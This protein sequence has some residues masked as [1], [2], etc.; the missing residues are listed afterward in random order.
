MRRCILLIGGCAGAGLAV[1]GWR[2]GLFYAAITETRTGAVIDAPA[3]LDLVRSGDLIL[4]DI[5][6]P[7]EW[8]ATGRPAGSIGLDMRRE[9]FTAE[10]T[11]IANGDRSAPIALICARGVRSAHLA[12]RMIEAGFTDIRDVPEG[13]LGSAAGPGWVA[14]GLPIDRS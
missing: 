2:S 5:R 9:D 8:A 7:E 14:R 4:V 10:L 3:A 1:A 12:N 11:R 6:R 13:M